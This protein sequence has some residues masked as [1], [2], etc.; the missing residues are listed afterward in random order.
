MRLSD[1]PLFD[2][3][4][5]SAHSVWVAAEG[6]THGVGIAGDASVPSGAEIGVTVGRLMASSSEMVLSLL[7]GPFTITSEGDLKLNGPTGAPGSTLT[8]RIK[9]EQ[10]APYLSITQDLSVS[11]VVAA[12]SSQPERKQLRYECLA[13]CNRR[14]DR[15]QDRRLDL[16]D[17][18][19]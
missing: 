2:E 5:R 1:S 3:I 12:G 13:G 4:Y 19:R 18:S 7:S 6:F 15:R 14:D 11:V 16:D 9:A 10:A 17:Q 8:A